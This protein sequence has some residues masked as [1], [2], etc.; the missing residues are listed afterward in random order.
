M[1]RTIRHGPII[2][3]PHSR[4]IRH[5]L[6][7]GR[8]GSGLYWPSPPGAIRGWRSPGATAS[9]LRL[10][11]LKFGYQP[12]ENPD[13]AHLSY[14]RKEDDL[15]RN[16]SHM[17][18]TP[19]RRSSEASTRWL[20]PYELR[21]APRAATSCSTRSS[22]PPPSRTTGSP[23]PRRSSWRIPS[24]TWAPNWSRKWRARP[25]TSRATAPPPRSCWP[26]PSSVM[27][28]ATSPPAPTRCC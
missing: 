26:L 28:F 18:R 20:T 12:S 25:T 1:K 17:T 22:A 9:T 11:V 23:S 5:A 19:G 6:W 2:L 3:R 13:R 7:A 14:I 4:V 16:N 24:K 10:G 8:H 21:S 27:D 15:W